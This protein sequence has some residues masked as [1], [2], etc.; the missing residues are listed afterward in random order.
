MSIEIED[1][2]NFNNYYSSIGNIMTWI[3]VVDSAV[4]IGLGAL[5]AGI[6]A[7]LLSSTQHRN[8][9]K[10]SKVER[11]FEMLKEVAEKVENFNHITLRYWALSSD[12]RRRLI[13]DSSIEKPNE[14][15]VTQNEFFDSF[16][17]LTKSESLLLLFGYKDASV[18]V[19]EYGDLIK[20]FYNR[21]K[22]TNK[23][24]EISDATSYRESMINKRSELFNLLNDIYK[25]I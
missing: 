8:E 5:I 1:L 24:F 23:P 17:E 14:L 10:K 20:D 4:K 6:I 21:V 3:E 7:F 22:D 15:S 25:T 12:W 9:L 18:Q 2:F 11:E 16:K 13:L 19:R